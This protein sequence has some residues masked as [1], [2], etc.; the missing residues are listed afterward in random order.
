MLIRRSFRVFAVDGPAPHIGT[1]SGWAVR[2]RVQGPLP[3]MATGEQQRD[4]CAGSGCSPPGAWILEGWAP[5][6]QG[7]S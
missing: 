4:G 5:A 3:A 2:F 1:L 6:V 7:P